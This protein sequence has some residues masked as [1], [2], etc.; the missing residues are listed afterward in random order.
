MSL[1]SNMD[2]TVK[3][4]LEKQRDSGDKGRPANRDDISIVLLTSAPAY[5]LI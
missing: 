4:V 5:R 2:F 1:E 3:P